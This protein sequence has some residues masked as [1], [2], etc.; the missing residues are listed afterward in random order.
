MPSVQVTQSTKRR[1]AERQATILFPACRYRF[2]YKKRESRLRQQLW[3][4]YTHGKQTLTELGERHGHTYEWVRARL[5]EYAVST[6]DDLTPGPTIIVPDT[7]F[8]GRHYGVTVFRSWSR[9]RNLWWNE[10]S[11]EKMEHYHY[12]R[13]ILEERG[14]TFAAAVI[15]GLR[16]LATVFNDIP[17]QICHFHQLQTV[18][19]YLT[20]KPK[21]DAGVELRRLA[22]TLTKTN[23]KI[24]T[25]ALATWEKRWHT[26][27]TEKTYVAGTKHWYHTHK[28]VYS[29]YKSLERNLP[30]LFTYQ[31][32]PKLNIPNTT[33]TID[34]YF[35][36]LKKKVTAHHGLRRDRRYKV[37]SELLKGS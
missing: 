31:K 6:S 11:S 4:E 24:F 3:R 26:F 8:W 16:G 2:Q 32:Y 27:Y 37:I 13:K 33:N 23:G 5:D 29:A 14:W 30:Y 17:V 22:L 15:D 10:V 28:N 36:G 7:T 18:T 35:A 34:S 21:T 9:K 12:G 20:R 1:Y 25:E 19:K